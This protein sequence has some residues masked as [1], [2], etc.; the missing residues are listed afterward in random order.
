VTVNDTAVTPVAETALTPVAETAL[1]AATHGRGSLLRIV[2]RP[3]SITPAL[4]VWDVLAPVLVLWLGA[5]LAGSPTSLGATVGPFPAIA[6]LVGLVAFAVLLGLGAYRHDAREGLELA[7]GLVVASGACVLVAAYTGSR[8]GWSLDADALAFAFVALPFGW[9]AGRA[10]LP[11]RRGA[12]RVLV[13][14]SGRVARQVA[15]LALRHRDA[16]FEV[17]GCLDD[18]PLDGVDGLTCLGGLTDLERVVTTHRVDRVIVTFT[19]QSDEQLLSIIRSCDASG[20]EIDAV[21]RLFDLMSTGPRTYDVGDLAL[22]RLGGG[23]PGLLDRAAKRTLDIAGSGLLLVALA[24]LMALGALAVLLSDGRPIMFRQERVGRDGRAFRIL[25]LRTMVRDAEAIGLVRIAALGDGGMDIAAAV[26][27][28]KPKH[29]PRITRLG[30][31]LRRTS[32]DEL[33]QLWNVL[34]GQM[35]LVGPRP[36]RPFECAALSDWETRRQAVRPGITGL[37][38]VTSRSD[39]DWGERMRLDYRYFRHWSLAGDLR[40]LARTVTV[41]LGRRGAV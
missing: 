26:A 7:S 17:V 35:S 34:V 29:D 2:T 6:L 1:A 15:A 18:D 41:V 8:L 30:H 10:A 14:G 36:L 24:P 38:Q 11:A 33:P 27:V 31:V 13:I 5:R 25:K 12:Q 3:A 4:V 19:R 32:I 16:G 21:P 28:L 22:V 39:A 20:V 40:I 9:L 37:W 23:R